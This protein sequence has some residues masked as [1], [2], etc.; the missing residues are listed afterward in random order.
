[1]TT[2]FATISDLAYAPFPDISHAVPELLKIVYRLATG[3]APGRRNG[4]DA[5]GDGRETVIIPAAL[6]QSGREDLNLR[7]LD[8]QSSALTRLRYA[9][10]GKSRHPS[11]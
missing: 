4:G 2:V 8:P 5:P 3:L 7:P 1:M 6:K 10:K 11:R 9:P